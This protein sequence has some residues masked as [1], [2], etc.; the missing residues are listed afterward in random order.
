M[1]KL[2]YSEGSVFLVPLEGGGYARGVVARS[3]P[4]GKVLLGYFFGP[5]LETIYN[6]ESNNLRAE[7]AALCIRFGDLGLVKNLWPIVGS[8]AQ[9]DR[10]KWP[11]TNTIRRD[12]FGMPKSILVRY[13]DDD[14]SKV[15]AEE[16][17]DNDCELPTDGLAGY[18]FVEAVLSKK[19]A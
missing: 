4:K 14:P 7:E 16:V 17:L 1:K 2:P 18:R 12:V 3:A 6:V 15:V 8:I 9:W 5:R 13:A 11:M 19:L 10:T